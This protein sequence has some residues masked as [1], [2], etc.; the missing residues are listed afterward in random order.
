MRSDISHR[1]AF[2]EMQAVE[3]RKKKKKKGNNELREKE[4]EDKGEKKEVTRE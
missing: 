2:Q 4:A 3:E 1:V